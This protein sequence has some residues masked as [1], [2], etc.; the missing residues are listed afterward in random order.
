VS[1]RSSIKEVIAAAVTT[2]AAEKA[3]VAHHRKPW[4]KTPC[5]AVVNRR[6]VVDLG[7]LECPPLAHFGAPK[8]SRYIIHLYRSCK[9]WQDHYNLVN[10]GKR[11]FFHLPKFTLLLPTAKF[12]DSAQIA[13]GLPGSDVHGP[14]APF[15][16]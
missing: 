3:K 13:A 8:N 16:G 6:W 11:R 10:S 9:D 5:I 4:D 12:T 15:R 7:S 1:Q 14:P 2:R